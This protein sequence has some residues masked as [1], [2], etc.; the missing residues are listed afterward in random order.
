MMGAEYMHRFDSCQGQATSPPGNSPWL[1]P[2]LIL[3]NP[4]HLHDRLTA[5]FRLAPWGRPEDCE[6]ALTCRMRSL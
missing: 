6:K 5:V 2:D 1:L 4:E 3:A